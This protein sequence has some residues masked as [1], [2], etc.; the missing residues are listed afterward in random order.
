MTLATCHLQPSLI[1]S[2]KAGAHPSGAI[3][4][5]P[6]SGYTIRLA[7][8]SQTRVKVAGSDKHNNLQN[9]N[10]IFGHLTLSQCKLLESNP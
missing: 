8:K 2:G 4:S 6:R 1:F 3:Y 10:N 9:Y 5:V 7:R